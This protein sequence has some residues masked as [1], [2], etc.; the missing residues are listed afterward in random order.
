ML[1]QCKAPIFSGNL[2]WFPLNIGDRYKISGK[3]KKKGITG[4]EAIR[5]FVLSKLHL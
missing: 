3:N 2:L 5:F 4:P 1:K